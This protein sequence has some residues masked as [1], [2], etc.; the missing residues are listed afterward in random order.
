MPALYHLGR[1]AS[2]ANT[3][4]ARG[5]EAL[6]Q[7]VGYTPKANEPTLAS[8]HYFLAT[9]YEKEGKKTEAK[10]AYQMALKLNPTVKLAAERL[11]RV[12]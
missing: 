6:L 2:R 5:Q 12:S 3:N 4:L 10:Q 11:K 7:H 8:A 1:V 9:L